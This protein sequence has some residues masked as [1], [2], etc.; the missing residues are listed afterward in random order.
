MTARL[1]VGVGA[2]LLERAGTRLARNGGFF[3]GNVVRD[4]SNGTR[5][6]NKGMAGFAGVWEKIQD[7]A[8]SATAP[9]EVMPFVGTAYLS[10]MAGRAC[11]GSGG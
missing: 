2:D 5:W 4:L 8:V 3:S 6:T 11:L 9:I 10:L 7:R 1:A